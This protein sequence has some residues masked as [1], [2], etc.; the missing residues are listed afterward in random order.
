MT[1]V[2][3]LRKLFVHARF[4]QVEVTRNDKTQLCDTKEVEVRAKFFYMKVIEF[5]HQIEKITVDLTE[6]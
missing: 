6:V 2:I 1:A 4:S 5:E 3:F